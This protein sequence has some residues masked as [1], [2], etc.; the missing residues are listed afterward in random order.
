M[1]ISAKI[2]LCFCYCYR[3]KARQVKEI[4]NIVSG[5]EKVFSSSAVKRDK[6]QVRSAS[7]GSSV[8]S[9]SPVSTLRLTAEGTPTEEPIWPEIKVNQDHSMGVKAK[10]V[11]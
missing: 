9:W 11:S 4:G 2:E 7:R 8:V 1:S 3:K 6:K 10:S 5:L